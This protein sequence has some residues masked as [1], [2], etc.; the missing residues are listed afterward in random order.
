M[1]ESLRD[2]AQDQGKIFW[3]G[4]EE[5]SNEHSIRFYGSYVKSSP[6]HADNSIY[7]SKM[8]TL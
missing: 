4:A 2:F 6:W 7:E 3:P 5:H 8:G 1:S